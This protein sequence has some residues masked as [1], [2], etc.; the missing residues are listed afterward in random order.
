[1]SGVPLIACAREGLVL[2]GASRG[3]RGLAL[4]CGASLVALMPAQDAS[5][6]SAMK[7]VVPKSGTIAGEPYPY[8]MTRT[9]R[10]YYSSLAPGR[11]ACATVTVKGKAVTLVGNFGGGKESRSTCHVPAGS[12]VYINAYTTHCSTVEGEHP[13]FGPNAS[14]VRKCAL[15]VNKYTVRVGINAWLDGR[16]VTL[17]G[18]NFWDGTP[19]FPVTIKEQE[20]EAA[21]WGWSLLLRPL[22]K[23]THTV[24]IQVKT[25]NPAKKPLTESRITLHVS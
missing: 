9:W 22:P 21:A 23:G 24:R 3:K 19:A 16:Q 7:D 1:M 5:A 15:G 8:W 17:F 25:P 4:A 6:A 11:K 12:A 10:L 14:E 20:A 2:F 18:H 13:G